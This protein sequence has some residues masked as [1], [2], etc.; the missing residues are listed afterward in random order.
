MGYSY[1]ARGHLCCDCCPASDGVRK[2][3]C[4]FGYCKPTAMCAP[5]RAK[6]PAAAWRK[7]HRDGGCD[8]AHE[9][10]Q[11]RERA[12]VAALEEG[13]A[14]LSAALGF[15]D[16]TGRVQVV[17]DTRDGPIGRVIHET[18]YDKRDDDAV[19][20]LDEFERLHGGPFPV[21]PSDFDGRAGRGMS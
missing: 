19:C 11:A 4:P 18:I 13:R 17:F 7:L 14:V 2:R 15:F 12:K 8:V 20:T 1:D 3:A 6:Y 16:G 9:R 21:A 10:F 5:C